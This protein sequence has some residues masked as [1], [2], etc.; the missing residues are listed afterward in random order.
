[1]RY[2]VN[3]PLIGAFLLGWMIIHV[4]ML[5][6]PAR[7]GD[8]AL[9]T[10]FALAFGSMIHG[11]LLAVTVL[12]CALAGGFDWVP[13]DGRGARVFLVLLAFVGLALVCALP[14]GISMET[15]GRLHNARWD[16]TTILA[17]RA[18][19]SGLP[20]L[21]I[22]YLAWLIN[23]PEPM[24]QLPGIRYAVL[25]A[26]GILAIIGAVVSVQELARWN[27]QAAASAAAEQAEEVEKAD[28]TRQ[29]FAALTDADSLFKW[30]Q[31]STYASPEDVRLEAMRRIAA[32]PN[33][34]AELIEVLGS[35]NP[36]W[37]SEGVRFVADLAF[38]PSPALA[39]AVRRRLDAYAQTLADEAKTVTYDGDKR[40]DYYEVSKL[41]DAL[42]AARRLAEV[43]RADL[44]PQIEAI[45]RAVALYPK[46][47]AASS[48]PR[49]AGE[50]EK[51]IAARLAAP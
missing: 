11:V 43:S 3:L 19:G 50:A 26:I 36:L 1:M 35:D 46:S 22:A 17:S 41:R 24:R 33:L 28:K 48:F 39:E 10:A 2:L 29:E 51:Y 44:R 31:Y 34:D 18:V 42:K 23:A 32:R 45:R 30:Y 40:L 4:T 38:A 12:G 9:G 16:P 6:T 15:V 8:A 7:G 13:A 25:A 49:E 5:S 27:Q 20:M 21:L 14:L 47:N 37:A